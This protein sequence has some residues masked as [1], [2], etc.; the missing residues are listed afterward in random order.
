M[1][2][3]WSLETIEPFGRLD[4]VVNAVGGGAG[5]ELHPAETYPREAWD[6]IMELNLRSTI[7]P[8]QAAVRSMIE[9]GHGGA[10]LNMSSVR[11]NLGID[12]GYSAYVAAKGAISSL[13]RQWATEWARHDIRVNAIMPTFV[14]T[15]QVASLLADP[16]FKQGIVGRIPMRRIG[17]LRDLVGP[18]D[19]PL[20][21]CRVVRDRA[22]AR[23]RR[24]PHRDAIATAQEPPMPTATLDL[25]KVTP[26]VYTTTKLRG[27]N[28]SFVTT[29]DGVVVI[30]TPQL[31]TRAV[32]MRAEAESHGPIR[33]LIN[34]EN[35]VD[36][37]FGNWWFRGAG[38]VVNHQALY[39]IFMD[40]NA[41]LDP[42]AYALEAI[43]TDDPEARAAHPRSR[44]VLRQPA[45]RDR[46]VHGRPDAAGRRPHVPLPVDARPHPGPARGPRARGARRVHRRHDLQRGPD[47]ADDLE[48]RP[49]ARGAGADP[50]A[51]GRRLP[52]PG[53]RPGR[54]ARVRRRTSGRC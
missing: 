11:A 20:L 35:H 53:P 42:F 23:H 13:T 27:C 5:K 25:E 21:R 22:G 19:L 49:V 36:H 38:E 40:P 51:P 4:I 50:G 28:P 29:S 3:G 48:R 45:A 6:W 12:A 18:G 44:P 17:E 10:V 33:Y 7:V 26:N 47:V 31:P 54:D 46:R 41:A 15:P 43:P 37:I 14:D 32:A 16:A 1:R 24:R 2:I 8:T 30:D 39:D 52:G 34:T 9:A